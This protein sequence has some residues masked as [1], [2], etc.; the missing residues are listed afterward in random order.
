M[1][2]HRQGNGLQT[3]LQHLGFLVTI[4]VVFLASQ[5]LLF[6]MALSG[7]PW[8]WFFVASSALLIVGGG[9]I[10]CAKFPL[11]RSGR[12]FTFGMKSVP[13]DL[14]GFYQWGWRVFLFGV[15]LSLCLLLSTP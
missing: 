10:G 1:D 14:R 7:A 5:V 6:F 4:I 9:L 12:F 3:F 15:V 13:E 8:I 2:T 11:Y